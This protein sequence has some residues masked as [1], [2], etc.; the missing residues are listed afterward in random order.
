MSTETLIK[1]AGGNGTAIRI[2]NDPLTR[3]EYERIGSDLGERLENRGAEQ[4]GFLVLNEHHFEMAGGE[5][6][7][8]ASRAAALLFSQADD[9]KDVSFTVS[10]FNGTV[11][12]TVEQL[13]DDKFNVRCVFP[14][15][16]TDV[17]EVT[18]GDG[19]PASIVDLGGIVHVVIEAPFPEDPKV[20][21]QEHHSITEKFNLGERDAVGIVWF[22]RIGD[23][24]EMHPVVW[25][26]AI[27]TFFYETSCGSG[28]IALGRVTN[29]PSII[30]PSGKSIS[31][32][33]TDDAVILE[34]E[35]E[36]VPV[37]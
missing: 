19:T 24:I 37:D 2:I 7:G 13:S 6:C 3:S 10:G 1:A 22:E 36:V 4:A 26:K 35:M 34:S 28:T 29:V 30:Q 20:Y 23:A 5:F 14:G 15:M 21:E 8:N 33:I 17:T 9:K 11:S 27:N 32:Q 31:A 12:A 16:P 18:L 25:V